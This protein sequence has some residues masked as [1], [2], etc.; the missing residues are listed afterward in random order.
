[1]TIFAG[2]LFL[3]PI[4][5]LALVLNK[6]FVFVQRG[7]QPLTALVPDRLA[8]G[9]TMTAVATIIL[10][11]LACFLAGLFARTLLAQKLV[12]GLEQFVLSN[13]RATNI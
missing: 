13:C 3:A 5:V 7:L 6:A 10:L 2:V 4:V 8:S 1:M 11:A 12:S 9:P